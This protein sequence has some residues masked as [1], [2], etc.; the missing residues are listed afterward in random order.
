M[1]KTPAE[2]R[3]DIQRL[4]E[5]G[6]AA[7]ALHLAESLSVSEPEVL[8]R[9]WSLIGSPRALA[10]LLPKLEGQLRDEVARIVTDGLPQVAIPR[11]DYPSLE[12]VATRLGA[13]GRVHHLVLQQLAL[14]EVAPR[15]D[16]RILH[17]EHAESLAREL[18]DLG[19]EALVA[20]FQARLAFALGEED[21]AEL[22]RE[23]LALGLEAREPRATALAEHLLA[24]TSGQ[25]PSA[26]TLVATGVVSSLRT[27]GLG[28]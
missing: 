18:G 26:E 24:L 11:G 3:A 17:V 13:Q 10:P 12:A 21:S 27:W 20:S 28:P 15:V 1:E 7:E 5:A 22:A 23:A 8:A 16:W 2:T 14:A 6:E 25:A 4:L 9:I 19:L